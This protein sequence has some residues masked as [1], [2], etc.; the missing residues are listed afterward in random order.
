MKP[1][2][3]CGEKRKFKVKVKAENMV[4]ELF[5]GNPR[6]GDRTELE[7]IESVDEGGRRVS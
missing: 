3:N 7:L 4:P 5:F 6:R 1:L 2:C